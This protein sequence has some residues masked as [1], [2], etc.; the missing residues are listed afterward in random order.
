MI[1]K[2]VSLSCP[3][4]RAIEDYRF[5]NRVSTESGAIRRLAEAGLRAR[6]APATAPQREREK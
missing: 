1:R 2:L 5:A 3:M 4:V 6:N